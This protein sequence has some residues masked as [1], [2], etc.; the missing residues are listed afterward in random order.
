MQWFRNWR[1][2]R[3]RPQP[4]ARRRPL[5]RR[6]SLEVLEDRLV[7]SINQAVSAAVD[8]GGNTI[9][10]DVH[11][12]GT[13]WQQVNQGS[14]VQ[15]DS[16]AKAVSASTNAG[17]GVYAF[18]VHKDGTLTTLNYSPSGDWNGPA[19]LGV[20]SAVAEQGGNGLVIDQNNNLWQYNPGAWGSP[21]T[22]LDSNVWQA[23]PTVDLHGE[24][25]VADVHLD[26]TAYLGSPAGGPFQYFASNIQSISGG[27]FLTSLY[28]VNF[29]GELD[30][31]YVADA[32]AASIVG[33][34][35]NPGNGG[36]F[37]VSVDYN[38]GN[39]VAMTFDD[40]VFQNGQYEGSGVYGAYA[41][42]NGTFLEVTTN[43]TLYQ[44]SPQAHEQWYYNF[45][46]HTFGQYWTNWTYEDSNV[47]FG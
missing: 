8:S 7:P 2:G 1:D 3:R 32:G 36:Y 9:T 21:W 27:K 31:W 30:Q 22:Y 47:Q 42:P 33:V 40:R 38:S 45:K 44:W 6:P 25:V 13:L 34:Y 23:T 18:V 35:A 29:S 24:A 46:T 16:N 26:G 37:D 11:T 28:T 12:D 5:A 20:K 10:F 15:V 19:Y 14:F 41:G 4:A 43:A 39:M 17:G